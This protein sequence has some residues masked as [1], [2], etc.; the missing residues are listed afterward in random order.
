MN[1]FSQSKFLNPRFVGDF[2]DD[3]LRSPEKM[4]KMWG[5]AYK[6]IID[7]RKKMRTVQQKNR[8]LEN[9]IVRLKNLVKHLKSVHR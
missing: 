7:L 3:D 1:I 5:L 4:R 6:Q 9:Q 8:R 2:T